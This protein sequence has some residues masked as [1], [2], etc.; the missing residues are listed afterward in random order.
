ME[1][2]KVDFTLVITKDELEVLNDFYLAFIKK[3]NS[4]HVKFSASKNGVSVTAYKTGTVLIQGS[5]IRSEIADIKKLLGRQD[6]AAIGS[7]EVGTGDVFGSM[8]VCAAYVS[9][10]NI[11]VLEKLNVRDSKTVTD[12]MILEL[13]P[14]IIELIPH[15]VIEISPTNYNQLVGLGRNMNYMK[16]IMHNAAILDL[17]KRLT[18]KS[19]PVIQDQFC[20]PN[21][22]FNYLIDEEEVYEDIQ[23]YTKAESVHISVAAAA[24]IARYYFLKKMDELSEIAGEDLVKGSQSTADEQLAR[25]VDA[26][27]SDILLEVA[28]TNFKNITKQNLL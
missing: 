19:I 21:L 28:K 23:F 16:A 8:F 1:E 14:Q 27:G 7:D 20:M 5:D 15:S 18:N 9:L 11:P 10:Q 17:T 13:A 22:Y 3:V 26:K 25:I 4:P 24:I 2:I 12:K 6:Y